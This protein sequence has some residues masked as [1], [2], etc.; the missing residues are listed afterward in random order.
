[1]LRGQVK[2]AA[3][4]LPKAEA[5]WASAPEKYREQRLE[6]LYV[7][8]AIQRGQGDLDGAIATY[9]DRDR[10]AHRILGTGDR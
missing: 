5:V 6:G 4:L 9:R 1:M 10:R 3:E 8:G 7:R 2:Q